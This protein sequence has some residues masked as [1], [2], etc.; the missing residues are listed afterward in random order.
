[1]YHQDED[2]D[3]DLLRPRASQGRLRLAELLDYPPQSAGEEEGHEDAWMNC[4]QGV[5]GEK[6]YNGLAQRLG[7]SVDY[8]MEGQ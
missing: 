7:H 1:M 8:S 2:D 6:P 4:M 5:Q 3:C